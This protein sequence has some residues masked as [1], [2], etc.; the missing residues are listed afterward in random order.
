[1][2]SSLAKSAIF[3]HDPNWGRIA[4]AAGYSGVVF[5]QDNLMVKLGDTMLMD[6][7]QP[8]VF[9]KNAAS[10]YLADTCGKHGTVYITVRRLDR[11]ATTG[12]LHPTRE[13]ISLSTPFC[14]GY[15]YISVELQRRY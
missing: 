4:A 1:M 15:I 13:I 10:K 11:A 12:L 9:D 3:G 2:G 6:K 8:L 5:D 7:G 14:K